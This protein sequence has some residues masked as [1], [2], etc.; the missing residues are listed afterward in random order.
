MTNTKKAIGMDMSTKTMT[1]LFITTVVAIVT[2]PISLRIRLFSY[3]IM[4]FITILMNTHLLNLK[5][6]YSTNIL[7][8]SH[9]KKRKEKEIS[10]HSITVAKDVDSSQS[11]KFLLIGFVAP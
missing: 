1:I 9:K 6:L 2:I 10:T 11:D 3:V 8:K 7:A 5:R 4:N